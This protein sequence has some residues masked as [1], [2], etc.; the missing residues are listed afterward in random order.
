MKNKTLKIGELK[1]ES[2][3][4]ALPEENHY[5]VKGGSGYTYTCGGLCFTYTYAPC[6]SNWWVD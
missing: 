4:T 3:V 1:L 6:K 2:F 5:T